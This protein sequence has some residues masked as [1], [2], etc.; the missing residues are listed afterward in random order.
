MLDTT[1][2]ANPTA[3]DVLNWASDAPKGGKAVLNRVLKDGATVPLFFAQ[4]GPSWEL[5]FRR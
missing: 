1:N 4:T 5:T 3:G 2:P